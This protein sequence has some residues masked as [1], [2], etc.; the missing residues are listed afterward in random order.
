MAGLFDNVYNP[1]V[2]S[3]LANLSSD[4]VFTPPEVANKMLDMLP[5]ELF[6][7]PDTKFL[8]PA[9][10]S[11]VFLREIVK[12][13]LVGLENQIP[14]IQ[15]RINHIM[16]DMVYGIAITELTSLIARRSLYCSK[17]ASGEFSVA[18]FDNVDGN[19]RYKLVR[20][21]W[22]NGKCIYCG[23][24]QASNDRPDELESH[25][26][27]FIHWL[28][29]EEIFNMK[30]DVVIGNPPY[31]LSDGG[32]QASAMPIYNLFVDQAKKLLPN[33]IVMVI[34][35]R[36]FTGGKNL[37][38][39]RSNM[40]HDIRLKE[41]H[42]YWTASDCFPG[43]EIKGG[44]CYFLW[45]RNHN[46]DC[47]V[48]THEKDTIVSQMTRPLLE[49]NSDVFIRQNKAVSILHKVREKQEKSFST[50][51][52][53]A[54][55]F[56]LRTFFKSFDSKNSEPGFVKVY[57]NHSQGYI[58]SKKVLRGIEF[59][60][61]WKVYVPEAVGTGDTRT[62]VLKPILG[63]PGSI[64]TETY[65]MNGPWKNKEEAENV[66]SYINTKFF[67]FMLGIKKITQHTTIK[68]YEFV[69]MQDFSKSWCDEELYKKYSL[70]DE[71]IEFIENSVWC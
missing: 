57:A 34:P 18:R 67:H 12:R 54:M 58:D 5:Q 8:D 70:S 63:E 30:F 35:A 32:A 6:S 2:L 17:N 59:I 16:H 28:K 66:M 68:V 44:V 7:N 22:E 69:P 26:Y 9:C 24:S 52:N 56:G 27:E 47:K 33:Y 13:L 64:C 37:D 61:K 46:G 71:E 53:S 39:F 11:G 49:A 20:H 62:D 15:Q 50:M 14:D 43:V 19:I 41:L 29:P 31:Q 10:K 25:A 42:D 48:Y 21:T 51:V 1:D 23:A 36:W 65:V 60:E 4:E 45:D 3:C 38:E 40:L 55:T